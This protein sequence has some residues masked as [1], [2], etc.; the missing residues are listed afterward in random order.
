MQFLKTTQTCSSSTLEIILNISA[1]Q[2]SCSIHTE[3]T[4]SCFGKRPLELLLQLSQQFHPGSHFCEDVCQYTCQQKTSQREVSCKCQMMHSGFHMYLHVRCKSLK[5]HWTNWVQRTYLCF[6]I[7][8]LCGFSTAQKPIAEH[9]AL[10]FFVFPVPQE[11]STCSG[12]IPYKPAWCFLPQKQ[13]NQ[14]PKGPPN[15]SRAEVAVTQ[16]NIL[17]A[18]FLCN[19][20]AAP[21]VRQH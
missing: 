4:P 15:Q 11:A 2:K 5:C 6:V 8:N 21:F 10:A 13:E 12:D 20:R 19:S 3:R 16:W 17:F 1:R 18:H 14:E 7:C 9:K